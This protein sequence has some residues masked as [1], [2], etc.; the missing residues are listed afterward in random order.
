M[1]KPIQFLEKTNRCRNCAQRDGT[2]CAILTCEQL[3]R[4][5]AIMAWV[6]FRPGQT[7]FTEGDDLENY[8]NVAD[9]VVRLVRFLPNG[10]RVVLE[11]LYKGDFLGLNAKGR[12]AYTAEAITPVKLC[13]FPKSRLLALFKEIPKMESQLFGMHADKLVTAQNR[14]V[15]LTRKSPCERLAAFL[16]TLAE[17]DA[18]KA[19]A[20][21]LTLPVAREDI[22]AY[23]G[24]TIWTVSRAFSELRRNG[25]I[26]I[27]G[28]KRIRLEN[29]AKLRDL[30]EG[31]G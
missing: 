25:L 1:S 10:R 14:I 27:E 17:K 16:L 9:G 19:K 20:D 3:D 22:A 6:Y 31:L 18:L 4:L 21:G 28:S 15:D 5:D 7:I 11:F 23:L 2:L 12:Y 29:K 24:L 30:A 13:R 8:Y 26:R